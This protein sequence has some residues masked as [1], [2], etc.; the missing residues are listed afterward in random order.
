MEWTTYGRDRVALEALYNDSTYFKERYT[1]TYDTSG[2][3]ASVFTSSTNTV[4]YNFRTNVN[5]GL[6]D[7]KV[8][9]IIVPLYYDVAFTETIIKNGIEIYGFRD[10][11]TP[12]HYLFNV[13]GADEYGEH[14]CLH[15]GVDVTDTSFCVINSSTVSDAADLSSLITA[16]NA[17]NTSYGNKYVIQPLVALD[18]KTGFYLIAGNTTILEP[19]TEVQV[20]DKK[21]MVVANGICVEI[22]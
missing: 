8:T 5:Y 3:W 11:A 13:I 10:A 19:L 17:A 15:C 20:Q 7:N 16:Y 12:S 9:G 2:E 6:V 21:F 1:Y 4:R 22:E 18:E 14:F